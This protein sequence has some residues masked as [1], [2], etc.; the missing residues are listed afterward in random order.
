MRISIPQITGKKAAIVVGS[1]AGA[2]V[3]IGGSLYAVGVFGQQVSLTV[4]GD[5]TEVRTTASTVE[6][7]LDEQEVVLRANDEV[8]PS[9]GTSLNGVETVTVRYGKNLE[10][11][12]DG[13]EQEVVTHE[14][15]FGDALDALEATPEAEAFTSQVLTDSIPRNGDELIVSNPKE[16]VIT[17]DGEDHPITSAAPT[18]GEVFEAAEIEIG[19]LDEVTP[20]VETYLTQETTD[21]KV[22]RI[23]KVTKTEKSEIEFEVEVQDDETL[24]TGQRRVVTE[25]QPGEEEAEVELLLADGE[26]RERNVISRSTV[27]EPVTQV[28]RRGTKQPEPTPTQQSSSGGSSSSA[29]SSSAP[30]VASGS[31]WD[32]L[33]Q[34]E[35]GG[36]WSINTG[37]GYYGGLQ[38]SAATWRSVGGSGLP[39]QHSRE[40]QIRRGQILQ[41]RA[42]WGQ[43]PSCT[44]QLGLR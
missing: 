7:F 18:V 13:E 21:L 17:A 4:E 26:E 41:Q 34:C 28:E 30:A 15:T 35:S 27:R 11:L 39:H 23:E 1:A 3:L 43:W 8:D 24:E 20:A 12:I 36:N 37:N 38:F 31:V 33:A 10:L 25:G 19:E 9:L 6:E 22:V 44:R 14:L 32:R 29:A 42:G 16:L 2:A 5:L 40:E